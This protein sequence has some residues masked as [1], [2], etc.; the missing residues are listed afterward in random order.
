MLELVL[1][2]CNLLFISNLARIHSFMASKRGLYILYNI[3]YYVPH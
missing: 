2:R 3:D 1:N